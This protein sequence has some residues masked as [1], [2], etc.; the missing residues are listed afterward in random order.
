MTKETEISLG[1][2][3]EVTHGNMAPDFEENLGLPSTGLSDD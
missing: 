2:V 1:A 3:T